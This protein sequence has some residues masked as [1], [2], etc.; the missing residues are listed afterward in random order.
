MKDIQ[1]DE[2]LEIVIGPRN[3]LEIVDGREQFEQS[4]R[5]WLTAYLYEEIGEFNSPSVLRSIELQIERVARAHGRIDSISSVVV[6]PSEDA[7]DAIDV[8]II[9][10]TGETFDLTVS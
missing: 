10:L 7:V 8:S 1:L 4:L 9:Y 6:S 5:I 3:D 2:N